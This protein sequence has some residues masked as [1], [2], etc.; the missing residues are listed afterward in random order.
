LVRRHQLRDT[1][2]TLVGDSVTA[3]K[4]A[5]DMSFRG[6]AV[7]RAA[8]VFTYLMSKFGIVVSQVRHIPGVDNDVPDAISRNLAVSKKGILWKNLVPKGNLVGLDNWSLKL[9]T[10]CSPMES[11][12]D[13]DD[14]S[15]FWKKVVD[16][17][18]E[19]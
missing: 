2:I 8:L 9:I 16:L 17:F 18:S 15:A 3:L 4:W 1:A 19:L 5:E 7:R 11:L 12:L 14:Y 10:L 6:Y 13:P